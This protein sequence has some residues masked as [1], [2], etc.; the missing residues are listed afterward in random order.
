MPH[1]NGGAVPRQRIVRT[2]RRSTRPA[3][4]HDARGLPLKAVALSAVA[5]SLASVGAENSVP[6]V[7][8]QF[9]AS[10]PSLHLLQLAE[11][12]DIVDPAFEDFS[13]FVEVDLTGDRLVDV[14]AVVVQ[15]GSPIRYGVVAFNGSRAGFGPRQWIVRLEPER[16]VGV[17]VR[18]RQRLD[19]A[20]CVECDSNPFVRW[21]GTGYSENFWVPGDSPA[22][23]DRASKGVTPV[24]LRV[25]PTEAGR[26][27]GQTTGVYN[28][29]SPPV[30]QRGRRRSL[31]QSGG[32]RERSPPGRF[33]STTR[34]NGSFLHRL[35]RAARASGTDAAR[36]SGPLNPVALR[37][38]RSNSSGSPPLFVRAPW[39]WMKP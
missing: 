27:I 25:S 23:F 5:L 4:T 31:V 32:R 29:R 7:I 16:I 22:T 34:L 15:P 24:G 10:N 1:R 11:V 18:Q 26:I 6:P 33:R 28:R 38:S 19:I 20:Y 36:R 39:S 35:S 8:E 37:R 21:D 17:H 12:R 2:A 3:G 30:G 14:A 13:P 9:L